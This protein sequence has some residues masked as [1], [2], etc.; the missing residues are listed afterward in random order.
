MKPG[1]IPSPSTNLICSKD[2]DLL[3]ITILVSSPVAPVDEVKSVSV[4]VGDSVTLNTDLTEIQTDD[5]TQSRFEHQN[6]P[7][8]EINRKAR[9]ISTY[10]DT[11]GRF[12]DKLQLDYLTGSLTIRNIGIKHSG[13]HEADIST[14]S[15]SSKHTIH[16]TFNVT[17]S[18]ECFSCF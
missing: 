9:K 6:S 3:S 17:V 13:L 8:A 1:D 18:G 2:S 5:E 14:S 16:K 7:V 12:R 15:S 11:D 10:D 4:L